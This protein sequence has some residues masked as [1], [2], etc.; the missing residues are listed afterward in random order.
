MLFVFWGLKYTIERP[1]ILVE[2]FSVFL[3][4]QIPYQ[5]FICR[6]YQQHNKIDKSLYERK[7][8]VPHVRH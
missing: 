3:S 5:Q 2:K 7:L 1:A 6:G 8:Y 4:S